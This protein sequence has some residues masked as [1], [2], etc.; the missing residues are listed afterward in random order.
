MT[1]VLVGYA[2]VTKVVKEIPIYRALQ[3]GKQVP[4]DLQELSLEH[5]TRRIQTP[6]GRFGKFL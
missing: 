3:L 5:M 6:V 4:L 2:I 1:I